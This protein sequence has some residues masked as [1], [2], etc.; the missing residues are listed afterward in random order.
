MPAIVIIACLLAVLRFRYEGI[1]PPESPLTEALAEPVWLALEVPV[2]EELGVPVT[3]S[4]CR[5]S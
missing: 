1:T 3:L 5:G 4:G 2:T